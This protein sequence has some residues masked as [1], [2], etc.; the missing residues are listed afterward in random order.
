MGVLV[1]GLIGI[2]RVVL[3]MGG[4]DFFQNS[5]GWTGKGMTYPRFNGDHI[6][7]IWSSPL[8]LR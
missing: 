5:A 7:Q 3:E 8:R 4:R 1:D 6:A 2:K